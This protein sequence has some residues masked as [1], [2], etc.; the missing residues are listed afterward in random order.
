MFTFAAITG[1]V[2][3]APFYIILALLAALGA[4]YLFFDAKTSK[5]ETSLVTTQAKLGQVL[6]SNKSLEL[7]NQK[8]QKEFEASI[9]EQDSIRTNDQRL[10][11]KAKKARDEAKVLG[12]KQAVVRATDPEEFLREVN[13][14]I[15]CDFE[16]YGQPMTCRD[17]VEA[18]K[19]GAK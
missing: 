10:S 15:G 11:D 2:K 5:L 13:R 18:P 6:Q 1:F 7:D 4:G 3:T 14:D 9:A 16:G 8:K 12:E 19:P 17:T